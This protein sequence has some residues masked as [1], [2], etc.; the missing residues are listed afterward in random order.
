MHGRGPQ[1]QAPPESYWT[2]MFRDIENPGSTEGLSA[3]RQWQHARMEIVLQLLC[4]KIMSSIIYQH[5]WRE[6]KG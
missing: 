6:Q 3:A 2:C 1:G 5:A 4:V